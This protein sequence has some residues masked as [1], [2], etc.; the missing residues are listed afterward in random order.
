M[1]AVTIS[2]GCPVVTVGDPV[3]VT[4]LVADT[5]LF[6]LLVAVR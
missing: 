6:A 2:R 1:A 3:K 4:L 5:E